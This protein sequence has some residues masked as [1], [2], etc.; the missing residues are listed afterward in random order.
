MKKLLIICLLLLTYTNI[1]AQDKE[2][3]AWEFRW[4]TVNT[5]RVFDL[6]YFIQDT[7]HFGFQW[8]ASKLM[9]DSLKNNCFASHRYNDYL[10]TNAQLLYNIT[11]PTWL[12]KGSYHPGFWY[13]PF[14]TYE[15]T[16]PLDANATNFGKILRLA[17]GSN[18][19]FGFKYRRV[20]PSTNPTDVNYSRMVL[21]KS[22]ASSSEKIVLNNIIPKPATDYIT[23][24]INGINTTLKRGV[25]VDMLIE[26]YNVMGILIHSTPSASQ[27]PLN[28]GNFKIDISSLAPDIY[29]VKMVASNGCCSIVEKFVKIKS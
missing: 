11:A 18:P 12:N 15:P 22:L 3:T 4:G 2:P 19:I 26:I 17:D 25:E 5:Q 27:P 24:N 1:F 14:M 13:A 9:N 28:E 21:V 8:A 10:N 6:D 20:E 16:L 23:L 29:F 7:F